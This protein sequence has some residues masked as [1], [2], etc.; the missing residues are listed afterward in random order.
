MEEKIENKLEF[1]QDSKDSILVDALFF[2][3]NAIEIYFSQSEVGESQIKIWNKH[4][5][6][7]IYGS[8][9]ILEDKIS[10]LKK[11][12][13]KRKNFKH[14][15]PDVS[16][17]FLAELKITLID[18]ATQIHWNQD[19]L[20]PFYIYNPEDPCSALINYYHSCQ[21]KLK[22]QRNKILENHLFQ[23]GPQ[24]IYSLR[25]ISQPFLEIST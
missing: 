25:N 6:R 12:N 16:L 3:N 9:L 20:T 8:S 21:K 2:V 23:W 24:I 13:M 11:K 1:F 4:L 22:T 19:D 14:L 18:H 7:L 15:D 5:Y 17:N 10:S